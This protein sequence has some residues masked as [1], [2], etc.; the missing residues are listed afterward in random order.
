MAKT[1]RDNNDLYFCIY[2][3]ESIKLLIVS[4]LLFQ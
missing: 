1:M 4:L 2:M 3:N